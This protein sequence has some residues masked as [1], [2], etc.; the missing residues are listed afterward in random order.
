VTTVVAKAC[1]SVER[2]ITTTYAYDI[3][4]ERVQLVASSSSS[5]AT[6]TY[7]FPIYN[8]ATSSG[9]VTITKHIFANGEDVADVQGSTSTAAVHYVHDDN[10]QG[11]NIVSNAG[12]TI[13]NEFSYYPFGGMRTSKKANTFSESRRYTSHEYDS[14]TSLDYMDARYYD[15]NAAR[16]L[17]SV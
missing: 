4:D 8:V 9:K 14:G 16:F 10:L 11:A 15:Q 1:P 17:M 13:E 7:P 5:R 3:N 12:A 2:V 6:T